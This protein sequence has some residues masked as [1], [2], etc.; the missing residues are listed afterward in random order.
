MLSTS[1]ILATLAIGTHAVPGKNTVATDDAMVNLE[2][3]LKYL[4]VTV[5][6]D[7]GVGNVGHGANQ[8]RVQALVNSSY[9]V[10][11]CQLYS[12][13][14]SLS[15]ASASQS[16]TPAG[17][18]KACSYTSGKTY[19]ST[20]TLWK[21][22]ANNEAQCCNACVATDGCAAATFETSSQD[23][24]GGSGPQ[25]WEG[26]G[27]HM[28]DV[29]A[30]K[31]TGG[32]SIADLKKKYDGRLGDMSKFDAFMD[33]GV[34]FFV[35]DLQHYVDIFFTRQHQSFSRAME[36]QQ[37]RDMVFIDFQGA[38]LDLFDRV[39]EFGATQGIQFTDNN[40]ATNVR[41]TL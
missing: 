27:I 17:L 35:Y 7:N 4:P 3:V 15:T 20:D 1:V 37:W 6:E 28:P 5:A 40:G 9:T 33:Y 25:S 30:A 16:M 39:G 31:T 24:S 12:S 38:K 22:F 36:G 21:V 11:N 41:C 32:L 19:G 14:S 2:F 26:F 34:T 29:T 18:G 13:A 8:A 23:H 10:P